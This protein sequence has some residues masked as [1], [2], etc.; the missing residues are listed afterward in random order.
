MQCASQAYKTDQ[1]EAQQAAASSS[2]GGT[3]YARLPADEHMTPGTPGTRAREPR[4]IQNAEC[5]YTFRRAIREA[6]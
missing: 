1:T 6:V 3:R 2:A 5:L 4:P